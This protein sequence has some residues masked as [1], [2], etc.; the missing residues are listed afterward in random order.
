MNL[1]SIAKLAKTAAYVRA[2]RRTYTMMHPIRGARRAILLRGLRTYVT[3]A[4]GVR[5]GAVLA[6]VPLAV[7]AA[8]SLRR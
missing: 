2:P 4:N 6:A 5:A 7:M 3:P 1:N 8:R